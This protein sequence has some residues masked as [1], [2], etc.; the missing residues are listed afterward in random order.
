M[1]PK[2]FSDNI[3]FTNIKIKHSSFIIIMRFL[4]VLKYNEYI[5][6]IVLC[7]GCIESII[8]LE[9]VLGCKNIKHLK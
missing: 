2:H 6:L 8:L 5:H 3:V 7:Q 9:N 4:I 1:F